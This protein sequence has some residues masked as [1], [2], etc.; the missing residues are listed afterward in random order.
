VPSYHHPRNPGVLERYD[1]DELV[2]AIQELLWLDGETWNA[3]KP[4]DVP[5]VLSG[6]TEML[7]LRDL[8]PKL[9]V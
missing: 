1:I 8:K 3:E 9:S 2:E 6:I 5:E 4:L 7:E